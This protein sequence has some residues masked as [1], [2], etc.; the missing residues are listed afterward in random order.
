M[1][2]GHSLF[3]TVDADSAKN[4]T[5]LLP[6]IMSVASLTWYTLL[7][8]MIAGSTEGRRPSM[9]SRRI[10]QEKLEKEP[11]LRSERESSTDVVALARVAEAAV[12]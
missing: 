12:A 2:I 5:P 8:P 3:Y 10:S 1:P 9:G 11:G 7:A 4:N 6:L